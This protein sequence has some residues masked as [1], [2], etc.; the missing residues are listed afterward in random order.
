MSLH[1]SGE[2]QCLLASLCPHSSCSLRNEWL[3]PKNQ[4]TLVHTSENKGI[5]GNSTATRPLSFPSLLPNI[6]FIYYFEE[7]E[8]QEWGWVLIH[9]AVSNVLSILHVLGAGNTTVNHSSVNLQLAE[10]TRPVPELPEHQAGS[11]KKNMYKQRIPYKDHR[12][13]KLYWVGAI[14]TDILE[15]LLRDLD[16]ENEK[17]LN[18]C[19]WFGKRESIGARVHSV[20]GQGVGRTCGL[21]EIEDTQQEH[22]GT[23]EVKGGKTYQGQVMEEATVSADN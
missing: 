15:H 22:G 6:S 2:S 7:W 23:E 10:K 14:R 21:R 4:P 18:K 8:T 20:Q 17:H 11:Y 3:L 9:A 19:R 12:R 1:S 5:W 13:K 16:L